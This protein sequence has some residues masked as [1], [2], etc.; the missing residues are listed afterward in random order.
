VSPA[1][2]I[3]LVGGPKDGDEGELPAGHPAEIVVRNY[4]GPDDVWMVALYERRRPG[5]FEFIG[6]TTE[7]EFFAGEE[8]RP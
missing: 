2:R 8:G 3:H 1:Q 6:E 7:E 4:R 5:V